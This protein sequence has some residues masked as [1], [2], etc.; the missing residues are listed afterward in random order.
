MRKGRNAYNTMNDESCRISNAYPYVFPVSSTH[1]EFPSNKNAIEQSGAPLG[2][3]V[4]PF[5]PLVDRSNITMHLPLMVD[6]NKELARCKNCHAYLNQFCD[7]TNLK[8][9]CAIC[10]ER[11][12]FTKSQTRYRYVDGTA[13]PELNSLVNDFPR[14][15]T[16]DEDGYIP[17]KLIS[18]N[19]IPTKIRP[20]V[21]VFLIQENMPVDVIQ[22]V[23]EALTHC[24][25]ML[26]KDVHVL[27]ITFSNRVCIYN[28]TAVK[29]DIQQESA[30]IPA[31]HIIHFVDESVDDSVDSG[32]VLEATEGA[33][34]NI[35][36]E[37]R[38]NYR[39]TMPL[40][41]VC[42]FKDCISSVGD[43]RNRIIN[44]LPLLFEANSGANSTSEALILPV[45]SA[46][47]DWIITKP[48]VDEPVASGEESSPG[49]GGAVLDM[50]KSF[51]IFNSEKNSNKWAKQAERDV[52]SYAAIESCSGVVLNAFISTNDSLRGDGD[53]SD[54]CKSL[55]RSCGHSGL[56][57]NL[58]SIVSFESQEVGLCR[59]SPLAEFTGGRLHRFVL[60]NYPKDEILRLKESLRRDLTKQ[61]ATKGVL[62][63]RASKPVESQATKVTGYTC[64]DDLL[65][66]VYRCARCCGD[67]TIGLELAYGDASE[68]EKVNSRGESS[69][70]VYIQVAF[71]YETL[72]EDSGDGSRTAEKRSD[73]NEYLAHIF[74]V[75]GLQQS[76][77]CLMQQVNA[78]ASAAEGDVPYYIETN[79]SRYYDP[80]KDLVC[81]KRLRVIT[82]ELEATSQAQR[83]CGAI[84][85]PSLGLLI[86]RN[87][88]NSARQGAQLTKGSVHPGLAVVHDWAVSI[89]L[90]TTINIAKKFNNGSVASHPDDTYLNE[91]ARYLQSLHLLQMMFG[92]YNFIRKFSH[93]LAT[94]SWL[95]D[96]LVSLVSTI[97]NVDAHNAA[98]LFYPAFHAIK[99]MGHTSDLPHVLTVNSELLQLRRESIVNTNAV[100]YLVDSLSSITMYFP[101][102]SPLQHAEKSNASTKCDVDTSQLY[103]NSSWIVNDVIRRVIL[104][105][106]TPNIYLSEAGT[107][108]AYYLNH[109]LIEDSD[110]SHSYQAFLRAVTAAAKQCI[111]SS[112]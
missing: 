3:F 19:K 88:L 55:G 79:L 60:G 24:L 59:L 75:L 48:E 74:N 7:V 26:H 22:S 37:A 65:P 43:S 1:K 96:E 63:V 83:L 85:N 35:D 99:D 13:L 42:H 40:S 17:S 69:E 84:H 49:I 70:V 50:L 29:K 44:A 87:A 25:S 101:F 86:A 14:V 4:K 76:Y 97:Q 54:A 89:L 56:S 93:H 27:L 12:L 105:P 41:D 30:Q 15:F 11:N 57:V 71:A 77:E 2:C 21:H 64:P 108:T 10:G 106:I 62:K 39:T 8:W 58:Y 91:A 98:T 92:V 111:E 103:A 6:S 104:A 110:D 33:A 47:V 46:V 107:D 73:E 16:G 94:S 112:K 95:S 109:Q 66:N 67:A 82:V 52:Y 45:I 100:A 36:S 51:N 61:I 68:P 81:V 28:F 23:V 80:N 32:S 5:L 20:L 38:R 53:P 72:V 102:S 18:S 34:T 78:K 9:I 90:A 31:A